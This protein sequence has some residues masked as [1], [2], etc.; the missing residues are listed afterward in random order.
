MNIPVLITKKDAAQRLGLCVRMIEKL[1]AAGR[2]RCVKISRRAVRFRPCDLD[3]F[4][5]DNVVGGK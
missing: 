2:L 3:A 1:V 5:E 4:A